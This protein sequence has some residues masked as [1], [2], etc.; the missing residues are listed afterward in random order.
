MGTWNWNMMDDF[1]LP[2][3]RVVA[4]TNLNNFE[5]AHRDFA[6]HCKCA[7]DLFVE[8]KLTFEFEYSLQ[9]CYSIRI[10]QGWVR[11]YLRANSVEPLA[12]IRI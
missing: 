6:M 9:G 7:D 3:G 8:T 2:D 5:S 10:N 11:H 4:T 12:I 1:T